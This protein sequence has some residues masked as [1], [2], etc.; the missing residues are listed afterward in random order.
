MTTRNAARE[1]GNSR[2]SRGWLLRVPRFAFPV[3]VAA[4]AAACGVG[5]K[6][7]GGAGQPPCVT[8]TIPRGA[9]LDEAVDSL[10]TARVISST[11]PFRVYARSRGLAGSLKSG[12]YEL[13]EGAGWRHVVAA[14][15]SGRGAE[16]R[17]TVR[18]GLTAAEVAEVADRQLRIPRDSFRAA[19]RDRA[20]LLEVSLDPAV[21]TL[22]GY[23]FP[24]TYTVPVGLGARELA[25]VMAREFE[26]RWRPA[27][28]R[29]LDSLGMTRHELVTL[30]S[31][32]EAEVRYAPDREFVSAV[33]HNRLKRGMALQ[34][35]PTVLY[36]HGRR[37]PRVWERHLQIRSPYNT[38]RN[39]GLPPG[40]I[41]QPGLASLEAALY[42]KAVGYLYFVA[43]PDG[44]HVFSETYN[45]HLA[46]IR[47]IRAVKTKRPPIRR[48]P[49]PARR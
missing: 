19:T 3:G 1:R 12:V 23:L 44:K 29:R 16:A 7:C 41:G 35:D 2:T 21:A 39:R 27:W 40:P 17:F 15:S 6:R 18:E 33:Y 9:S 30:A 13:P 28:N 48:T 31:I 32:I 36:A 37:L 10:L 8:V 46:A 43:Q 22:E 24:T 25:R 20:A 11:G 45:Q 49:P 42:P 38:Y 26:T 34:A 4:W 47:A 5:P 14:L